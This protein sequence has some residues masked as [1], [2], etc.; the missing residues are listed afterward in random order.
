MSFPKYN[1]CL[2]LIEG[3]LSDDC[4]VTAWLLPVCKYTDWTLIGL[5]GKYCPGSVF[6]T[7]GG[8]LAIQGYAER[9][10]GTVVY[11]V[12]LSLFPSKAL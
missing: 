10:V 2:L 1:Q 6:G 5:K 9:E 8:A 7:H 3:A 12:S 11:V 4:E